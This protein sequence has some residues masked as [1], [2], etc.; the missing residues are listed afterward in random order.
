[1]SD[2]IEKLEQYFRET[3]REQVVAD[4]EATEEFQNI[5]PIVDDFLTLN[6]DKMDDRDYAAMNTPDF[7]KKKRKVWDAM[8]PKYQHLENYCTIELR[9]IDENS[10]YFHPIFHLEEGVYISSQ[11]DSTNTHIYAL[12]F[13][14]EGDNYISVDIWDTL[15]DAV[16]VGWYT[17]RDVVVSALTTLNKLRNHVNSLNSYITDY[18]NRILVGESINEVTQ[19]FIGEI[20]TT[21]A[22]V[23]YMQKNKTIDSHLNNDN[24]GRRNGNNTARDIQEH[25]G[26]DS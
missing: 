12:R 19:A 21:S 9:G 4:W 8:Y 6:N 3:P 25:G 24:N 11:G 20:K 17:N 1:M 2:M 13:T 22:L 7:A 16:V 5:G 26:Q 15:L 14:I 10:T 18:I 23:N